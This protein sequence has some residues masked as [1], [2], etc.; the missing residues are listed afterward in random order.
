MRVAEI[1]F[2]FFTKHKLKHKKNPLFIRAGFE[3]LVLG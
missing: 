3:Y 1:T 2:Y